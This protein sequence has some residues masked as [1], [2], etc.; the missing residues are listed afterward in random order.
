MNIHCFLKYK[1]N[2]YMI[3]ICFKYKIKMEDLIN[4]FSELNL[5]IKKQFKK[6]K[7]QILILVAGEGIFWAKS[8]L[9]KLGKFES[10]FPHNKKYMYINKSFIETFMNKI[11]TLK[12][13]RFGIISSRM[14]GN[15]KDILKAIREFI[16]SL[17]EKTDMVA[18]K[19]HDN[20]EV[21]ESEPNKFKRDINK[22]IECRHNRFSKEKILII[23]SEPNKIGNTKENSIVLNYLFSENNLQES[24]KNPSILESIEKEQEKL[25]NYLQKLLSAK[26][27]DVREYLKNNPFNN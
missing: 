14:I 4:D 24:E 19:F 7:Y 17:P 9:P 1:K 21:T 11:T 8:K 26:P 22:I 6:N 15:I 23:E 5:K 13:T 2:I 10:D 3:F 25:I 16:P 20:S 18:Q 12:T 27:E